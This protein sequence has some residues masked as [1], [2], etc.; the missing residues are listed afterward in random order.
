M[1]TS[2][3]HAA[4][5]YT[6]SSNFGSFAYVTPTFLTTDT[7]VSGANLDR[8]SVSD[9][10][11]ACGSVS[12]DPSATFRDAGGVEQSDLILFGSTGGTNQNYY[13]ADRAFSQTGTYQSVVNTGATLTVSTADVVYRLTSNVGSFTYATDS[14]VTTERFLTPADLVGCK[15]ADGRSTCAGVDL[16]PNGSYRDAG[17]RQPSDTIIFGTAQNSNHNY[18]FVGNAFTAPGVRQSGRL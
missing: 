7:P 5:I 12:F 14:Y 11:Y 1:S 10:R 4:V 2:G 3:A 13:F 15:S 18:Y 17:G 8:C 16:D 9:S 6:F